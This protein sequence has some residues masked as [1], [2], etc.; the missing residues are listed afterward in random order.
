M[1]KRL[2]SYTSSCYQLAVFGP[3]DVHIESSATGNL[4]AFHA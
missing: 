3:P 2:E 4:D 1:M